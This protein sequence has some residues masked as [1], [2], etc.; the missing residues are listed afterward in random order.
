MTE[1]PPG[2]QVSLGARPCGLRPRR[3]E[4]T[5]RPQRSVQRRLQ[6]SCGVPEKSAR[7]THPRFTDGETEATE[8]YTLTP[9]TSLD[10]RWLN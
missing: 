1:S 2:A 8:N 5:Q 4:A 10:V 6:R 3:E 7:T 9:G